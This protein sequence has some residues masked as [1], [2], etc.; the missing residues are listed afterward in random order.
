MCMLSSVPGLAR[1]FD[2]GPADAC[3]HLAASEG[4]YKVSEWL[5]EQGSD[6]NV[7]DRFKRTPLEVRRGRR[8]ATDMPCLM[9]GLWSALWDHLQHNR[10]SSKGSTTDANAVCCLDR[11]RCAGTMWRSASCSSTTAPRSTRMAR[12]AAALP[13][14][15]LPPRHLADACGFHSSI[16]QEELLFS[17]KCTLLGDWYCWYCWYC[18]HAAC[19]CTAFCA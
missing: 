18:S 19:R 10:S 16:I 4:C 1:V 9:P 17:S 6:V 12:C 7:L 15:K 2:W 13:A 8:A 11:T 5:L 14:C 3:R